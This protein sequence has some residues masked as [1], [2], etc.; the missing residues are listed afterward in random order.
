MVPVIGWPGGLMVNINVKVIVRMSSGIPF[1]SEHKLC[2]S[3]Y[4]KS[5][6][7]QCKY[8]PF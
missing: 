7:K 2:A 6:L 1:Q 3:L 8:M 4:H 5:A